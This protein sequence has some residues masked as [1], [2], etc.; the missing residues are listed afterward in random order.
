MWKLLG[1]QGAFLVL[2]W[3]H[4]AVGVLAAPYN[5]SAVVLAVFSKKGHSSSEL[6]KG[7][8]L[9]AREQLNDPNFSRSVVLLIEYDAHSTVG[10]VI[11][12]PT[13]VQLAKLWPTIKGVQQH[14]D[15]LFLGGPVARGQILLLVQSDQA[16]ENTIHVF[17]NIYV[18]SSRHVLEQMIVQS[19]SRHGNT[20]RVYAGYAGWA[21]GQLE[22]E[23]LRGDWDVL[24][25]DA[26]S[27][28][29]DYQSND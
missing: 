27:I 24:K 28:F 18:S 3:N 26:S 6:A 23:V 17:E 21:P 19:T 2:L 22:K 10:L 9:I 5:Q 13:D 20:F 1:I 25:A 7:K 4:V 8:F 29:R 12:R 15:P 11:N 14:Q 16:P